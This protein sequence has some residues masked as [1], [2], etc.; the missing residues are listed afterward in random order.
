MPR[1]RSVPS[2]VHDSPEW[3]RASA[4]AR[5]MHRTLRP[6]AGELL[7]ARAHDQ[8]EPWAQFQRKAA[9]CGGYLSP[10]ECR[11]IVAACLA[12]ELWQ[13]R[14]GR[15]SITAFPP[16]FER[17]RQTRALGPRGGMT[18][19]EV[20]RNYRE[21]QKERSAAP[22]SET[23]SAPNT[24]TT[25]TAP[26]DHGNG[27]N[28]TSTA[29]PPPSP[30]PA[31]PAPFRGAEGGAGETSTDGNA[32]KAADTNNPQRPTDA[33]KRAT[34]DELAALPA[35]QRATVALAILGRDLSPALWSPR[36]DAA[37]GGDFAAILREGRWDSEKLA[38]LNAYLRTEGS[39]ARKLFAWDRAVADGT[40]PMSLGLL[41]GKRQGDGT[42]K[43]SGLKRL[44]DAAQAWAAKR[45]AAK[46]PTATPRTNTTS[47][48]GIQKTF[49]SLE[50][51]KAA[52]KGGT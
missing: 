31:P 9:E 2:A 47:T 24:H 52:S 42:R 26:T 39:T 50:E 19:A 37:E 22:P 40:V 49:A 7:L 35:A 16:S 23:P 27:N 28:T 14:D 18:R 48:P 38:G 20:Q 46:P 33:T 13:L 25:V 6:T 44:C 10:E 11:E 45:G 4:L 29:A 3:A 30:S 8:E 43:C 17:E 15:L 12:A 1:F 21:R 36:V 32:A 51:L 5:L 34:A 41:L